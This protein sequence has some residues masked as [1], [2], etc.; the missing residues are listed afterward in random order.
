MTWTYGGDPSANDRDKVRFLTGDTDVGDQLVTDEEIAWA[1]TGNDI[2][3]SSIIIAK[4]IA[5]E[6]SRRADTEV[7]DLRIWFS[8]RAKA[9]LRLAES[10]RLQ[11]I[12]LNV[13]PYSG[14]RTISDKTAVSNDTDRVRPAFTVSKHDNPAVPSQDETRDD[15]T[16]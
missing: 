4:A 12:T 7:D 6:F 13:V 10:L 5:A 1:L 3:S 2:Y 14:G 8:Q 16:S 11:S 15:F 9:Y